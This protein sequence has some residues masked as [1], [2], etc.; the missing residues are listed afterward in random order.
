MVGTPFGPTDSSKGQN[1][2]KTIDNDDEY[3]KY[4]FAFKGIHVI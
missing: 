4:V 2:I 3:D 1:K